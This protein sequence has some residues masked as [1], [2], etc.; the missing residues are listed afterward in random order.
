MKA[1]RFITNTACHILLAV[2]SVIW[3]LPIFYVILTSFRAEGGSYKSY[4]WPRGFTL[5]NYKELI[6]GINSKI[7][8]GTSIDFTR[9]FLNTLIIAIFST[10]LSA[11]FVLCVSYVMSRLRFKMRKPFMNIALILGMFPGFMSMIAVYYILKGLGLLETG[12]LKQV[13]LVL[14]YSGGAGLGFYMAK[15]FFD[16]ISKSIDEAA[17]IDGATKWDTFIR[18]TIPLSKPIITYTLITAF[19]GPWVD[20]IFAKVIMGNDTPYYTIA[21]GLWT[22]LEQEYVEYYYTQFYAGCVL[23]SIPIA[24]LFLLTQKCYAE[25]VAG[26]VKG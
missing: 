2:L 19:M 8:G 24:I 1:K 6:L 26:A 7:Q 15:G 3:V 17:Y 18:I 25:G 12:V 13:S 21:I 23:I 10:V 16:T 11:F 5:D 4:I 20:Y 22:M 14:V 9:W